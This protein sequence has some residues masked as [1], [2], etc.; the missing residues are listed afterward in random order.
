MFFQV[1]RN[2]GFLTVITDL[3]LGTS[4][5]ICENKPQVHDSN[6]FKYYT[7]MQLIKIEIKSFEQEEN[8][9]NFENFSTTKLYQTNEINLLILNATKQTKK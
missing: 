2:Y 1:F 9:C 7:F 6:Y 5:F 3:Q 4:V 8:V